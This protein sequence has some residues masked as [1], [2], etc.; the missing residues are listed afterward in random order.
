MDETKSITA[1]GQTTA[2]DF[3]DLWSV[4]SLRFLLWML[5]VGG[6]YFAYIALTEVVR[7]GFCEQTAIRIIPHIVT[8]VI[9][10]SAPFFVPRMRARTMMRSGP[11]LREARQLVISDRGIATRSDRAQC[12]FQWRAFNKVIERRNSF[13]FFQS[14]LHALIIPKRFF[15]TGEDIVSVRELVRAHF[16][17]KHRLLN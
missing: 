14:D 10:L 9:C 16:N 17:G 8:A 7:E 4:S 12:E 15:V 6:L 11:V 5:F 2:Q 13:L 1:A 3:V